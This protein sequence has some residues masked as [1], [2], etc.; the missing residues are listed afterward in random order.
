M[1]GGQS[2]QGA[3]TRNLS[4]REPGKLEMPTKPSTPHSVRIT[5]QRF[6]LPRDRRCANRFCAF[7]FR[8]RPLE[9]ENQEDSEECRALGGHIE[10]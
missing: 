7:F 8:L 9:G 5:P 6:R 10:K 1:S 2:G 4:D 3:G